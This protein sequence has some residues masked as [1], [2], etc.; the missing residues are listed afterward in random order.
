LAVSEFLFEDVD[1]DDFVRV[2]RGFERVSHDA[3]G[4]LR[5]LVHKHQLD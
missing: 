1:G 4:N 2:F 5:D 3:V